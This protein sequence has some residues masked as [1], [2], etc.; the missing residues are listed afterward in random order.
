MQ[1]KLKIFNL[2]YLNFHIFL[3]RNILL[4]IGISFVREVGT[5]P[6][7]YLNRIF[8]RIV[9]RFSEIFSFVQSKFIVLSCI[10]MRS[11]NTMLT[12]GP[13]QNGS[14]K[15]YFVCTRFVPNFYA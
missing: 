11:A 7:F 1:N 5:N 3:I 4:I 2:R 8:T 13:K 6:K 14:K 12:P 9:L 10:K 15:S